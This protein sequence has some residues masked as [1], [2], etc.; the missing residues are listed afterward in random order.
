MHTHNAIPGLTEAFSDR[1]NQW[2]N[3]EPLSD[4][5][6]LDDLVRS[7][8]EGQDEIG[9]EA[10]MFGSV[11]KAWSTEQGNYLTALGR[12][13]TSKTWTSQLIRLLWKIQHSMWI[14]RN[15]FVHKVGQSINQYENEAVDT[16]I[17]K[18]FIIG[19]NGLLQDYD[20]LFRGNV[21]TLLEGKTATKVLWIY[22]I[23]S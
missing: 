2:R 4:L 20:K 23:W 12:R 8:I 21:N 9:W 18:V 22:R 11:H 13:T 7:I 10:M 15:S 16:V 3:Q 1:I 19:R 17:W 6:F 14:H 5:Q